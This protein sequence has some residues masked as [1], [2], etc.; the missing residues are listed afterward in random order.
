MQEQK[1][2]TFEYLLYYGALLGM[3]WIFQYLF[4]IGRA[5]WEHFIYFYNLLNIVSPLL[6]Y[7]FYMKYK[8]QTPEVK[9]NV[10]R[11]VLFVVGI[12]F[13]GSFFEAA[14]RYAHYAF[15]DPSF[16]ADLSGH[17]GAAIAKSS[18][19]MFEDSSIFSKMTSEDIAMQKQMTES[20]V[21]SKAFFIIG[22][23]LNQIFYGFI[24]SFLIALLTRNRDYKTN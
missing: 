20:M 23:M 11:C 17:F 2:S 8:A 13:F 14:I 10:K 15:I 21:T 5:Y 3:F 24:F 4:L 19:K 16:F 18:E 1:K 12:C 7:V 6:M 22:F 9:H